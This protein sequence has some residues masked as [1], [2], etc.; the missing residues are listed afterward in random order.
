MKKIDYDL[1]KIELNEK[2]KLALSKKDVFLDIETTG[3]SPRN[4]SIYLIGLGFVD[5]ENSTI[6]VTQYF[7]ETS[8]DEGSSGCR[9]SR[10]V[11]ILL[12]LF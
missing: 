11:N 1:K 2:A 5:R 6:K 7:A 4:A 9:C 10:F 3:L 12:N 8:S